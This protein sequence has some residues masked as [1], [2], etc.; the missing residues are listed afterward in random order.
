MFPAPAALCEIVVTIVML[1]L[2]NGVLGSTDPVHPP[3]FLCFLKVCRAALCP[4]C[5]LKRLPLSPTKELERLLTVPYRALLRA[6][7]GELID[8]LLPCSLAAMFLY[9]NP[10]NCF[11]RSSA[12][13]AADGIFGVLVLLRLY[14]WPKGGTKN[15]FFCLPEYPRRSCLK[16]RRKRA[17]AHLLWR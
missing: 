10:G 9:R 13:I 6:Q 3:I 14:I 5:S 11:S 15:I 17:I 16:R 7:R 12:K 2:R 4:P 8:P 1:L